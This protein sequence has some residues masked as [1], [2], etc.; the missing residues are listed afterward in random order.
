MPQVLAGKLGD[1]RGP[2]G[3]E[4]LTLSVLEDSS[5]QVNV[6]G[7][8]GSASCRANSQ[9]KPAETPLPG[10]QPPTKTK[11]V[12]TESK[13]NSTGTAER[14]RMKQAR[15]AESGDFNT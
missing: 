13:L 5:S 3:G 11:L 12:G 6:G 9:N 15:G 10:P 7:S 2:G 1:R 14:P 4:P 8:G